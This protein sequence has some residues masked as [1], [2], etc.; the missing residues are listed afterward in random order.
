MHSH[1]AVLNISIREAQNM[2][3]TTITDFMRVTLDEEIHDR[4]IIPIGFLIYFLD[5]EGGIK[6]S[7]HLVVPGVFHGHNI[8]N[9][10]FSKLRRADVM[11]VSPMFSHPS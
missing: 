11:S 3:K 1:V 6:L 10:F 9:P 4:V 5:P 2:G 8:F 7:Y